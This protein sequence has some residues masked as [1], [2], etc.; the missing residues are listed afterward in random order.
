M[1]QILYTSSFCISLHVKKDAVWEGRRNVFSL[2]ASM[3]DNSLCFKLLGG[4][5]T[6]M[7]AFELFCSLVCLTLHSIESLG[8]HIH[9][10]LI[11]M[12][13]AL[14]LLFG[15]LLSCPKPH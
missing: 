11:K 5:G 6:K 4:Y 9:S 3:S 1:L 8:R 13:L 7:Q 14:F 15:E 12:G 10:Y 2:G